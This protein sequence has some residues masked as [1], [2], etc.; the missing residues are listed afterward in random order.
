MKDRRSSWPSTRTRRGADLQRG[1]LRPGGGPVHRRAWLVV[2]SH[3]EQAGHLPLRPPL[4][5]SAARR[6]APRPP[7]PGT[8]VSYRPLKGH[9]VLHRH[10]AHRPGRAAARLRG[11]RPTNRV[12]AVLE[13]CAKFNEGVLRPAELGRRQATRR[14]LKDGVV[15]PRPASRRPSAS[16]AEGGWQGL[17]HPADF[18][19]PGPAQDHR[20]G[21]HRRCST[22]PT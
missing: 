16:S 18:R 17:Q 3:P 14:S 5:G 9:A 20:R 13:E 8:T 4:A 1:R 19:R 2:N 12:E 22:A 15:T 7:P 11:S 21:L 10:L 6:Q